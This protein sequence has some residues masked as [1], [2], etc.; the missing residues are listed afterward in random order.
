MTHRKDLI[1]KGYRSHGFSNSKIQLKKV[2]MRRRTLIGR[3]DAL[4]ITNYRIVKMPKGSKQK[5]E[6][7]MKPKALRT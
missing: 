6:L 7:Y 1:K 5:Y 3:K 2:A 4:K